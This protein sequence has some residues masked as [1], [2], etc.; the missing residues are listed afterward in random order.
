M[1]APLCIL[2]AFSIFFAGCAGSTANPVDRYQFGDEKKS[3]EAVKIES[4]MIDQEIIA[5]NREIDNRD[6]W[7]SVFFVTGFLVIVPWFLMDCK[8]SE[9]AEIAALKARKKNLIIV[10]TENGCGSSDLAGGQ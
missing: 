9:E 7:N 2:L 6:F 10:A 5:K 3:C 4:Q 1:K 8:N